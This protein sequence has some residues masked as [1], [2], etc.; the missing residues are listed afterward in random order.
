MVARANAADLVGQLVAGPRR[1]PWLGTRLAL[2]GLY[3]ALT[4]WL[5]R[6]PAR[7]HWLTAW[8]IL[9]AA[10]MF[11]AMGLPFPWYVAWFWPVC[12]LRWDRLH[13]SLSGLCFG[14]SLA[15]T[16]GYGVLNQ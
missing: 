6:R 3:A 13:L 5:W 4:L 11:L 12:L 10:L 8:A 7:A 9:S 16:A 1:R 15:W 2:V 14:L